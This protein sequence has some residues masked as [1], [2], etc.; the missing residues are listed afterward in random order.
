MAYAYIISDTHIGATNPKNLSTFL[1][2]LRWLRSE[3]ARATDLLLLGDIFD[4]WIYGTNA[5]KTEVETTRKKFFDAAK[6]VVLELRSCER[7]G[8][9]LH[10]LPGNHDQYILKSLPE[11]SR[12]TR[13]E[14]IE[15]TL[16]DR[17]KAL[18]MHGHRFDAFNSNT[19][20]PALPETGDGKYPLGYYVARASLSASSGVGMKVIGAIL[21][22]LGGALM[23]ALVGDCPHNTIVEMILNAVGLS[24]SS[25]VL[26][27]PTTSDEKTMVAR[28][29][30]IYANTLQSEQKH[31]G[32]FHEMIEG[33]FGNVDALVAKF[34]PDYDV[35]IMGHFHQSSS[36]MV[37]KIS[38][39]TTGSWKKDGSIE[40]IRIGKCP[41]FYRLS[42]TGD[43]DIIVTPLYKDKPRRMS[44]PHPPHPPHHATIDD[45][46]NDLLNGSPLP[47][48]GLIRS[49]KASL[50]CKACHKVCSLLFKTEKNSFGYRTFVICALCRYSFA[51]G[52]NE[53]TEDLA[54]ASASEDF[55]RLAIEKIDTDTS[56]VALVFAS[57]C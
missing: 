35:V 21:R 28:L 49:G 25:N 42:P 8:L 44:L 10:Y 6:L 33:A 12:W 55:T 50:T 16:P 30:N 54:E 34:C 7:S 9:K 20:V 5:S 41:E 46:N 18:L 29:V 19:F 47:L 4:E 43:S 32:K 37:G 56:L 24:P 14:R 39:L 51:V 11:L 23:D 1:L 13:D 53:V 22:H 3:E 40:G 38:V 52:K 2:F 15:I 26:I 57:L 36:R 48:A 17:R 45:A 27:E 31:I